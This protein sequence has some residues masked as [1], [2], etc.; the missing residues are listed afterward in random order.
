MG[1]QRTWFSKPNQRDRKIC[2]ENEVFFHTDATQVVGKI[3]FSLS[4]IDGINFL[5]CSS[6][7]FH[8][9]KGIGVTII[10]KDNLGLPIQIT[11]LLHGGG[12]E[13]DIRSGTLPV[14]NIVGMGKAAEIAYLN[15]EQNIYKL[16]Q[17]ENKLA[18]ILKPNFKIILSL[19]MIFKIKYLEY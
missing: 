19:T 1:Q 16:E 2:K 5:S 14:H 11:P 6:H 15:L 7:K 13:R 4:D 17:L 8:G 18:D 9:P 3:Q 10:G 12:Q